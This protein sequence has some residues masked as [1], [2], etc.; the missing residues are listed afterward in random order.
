M[1]DIGSGKGKEP[2]DVML[3]ELGQCSRGTNAMASGEFYCDMCMETVHVREV[4][5]VPGCTHLFCIGCLS[6]Y[7]TAKVEDNVVSIGCP[8]PGCKDGTLYPEACQDVIPL[9]LFQR[10]GVALCDS[11]L[12]EFMFYCPFK[13]C[14]AL[15]VDEH[16]QC[17]AAIRKAECPC[18]SRMFCV[19][20][21]VSWH[22]DVTCEDFQRLR[23]DEGRLDDLLPRKIRE[24]SMAQPNPVG[25]CQSLQMLETHQGINV[26]HTSLISIGDMDNCKGKK[27]FIAM[28]QELGQCSQ[29]AN[30]M[31]RSEFYCTICMEAVDLKHLLL[32]KVA[33][34]SRWQRCPK[35]KMYVERAQGCVY[36]VCRYCLA[37]CSPKLHVQRADM[38]TD[39]VLH[40]SKLQVPASF[41]LPL[42]LPNV[43]GHTSLQQVQEDLVND[44][45]N[46]I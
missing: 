12:G 34:E 23:N 9:Q 19:Q 2:L 4:F 13:D 45:K 41:L 15:L 42:C 7:I 31:A 26:G 35:C 27:P 21:K 11:V 14:S 20:C 44:L 33:R 22:Y 1:E 18:C 40:Y 37:A 30:V 29:G 24:E 5:P 8:Q 25:S 32:R 6:Q 38:T 16:G 10:W 46:S 39:K 3:Q 17:E 28:L 36:I 43:Q